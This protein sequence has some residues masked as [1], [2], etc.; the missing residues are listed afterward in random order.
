[1]IIKIIKKVSDIQK[2]NEQKPQNSN[3]KWSV[4]EQYEPPMIPMTYDDIDEHMSE[5]FWK[6][7]W[8][9]I[10]NSTTPTKTQLV[11][12]IQRLINPKI[13]TYEVS[14]ETDKKNLI[15]KMDTI[16]KRNN[17]SVILIHR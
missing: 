11:N 13:E 15:K 1:M 12:N 16:L 6:V 7:S 17:F 4:R 2:L 8:I 9:M 10:I 3:S 5:N 14:S